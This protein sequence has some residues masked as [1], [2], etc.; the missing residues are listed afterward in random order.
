MGRGSGVDKV[1][2]VVGVHVQACVG[3]GGSHGT[4]KLKT[5]LLWLGFQCALANCGGGNGIGGEVMWTRQR[6]WWV[7]TFEHMMV[8]YYKS[9]S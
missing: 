2:V 1:M 9:V 4:K 8:S 6:R 7:Y 3:G 5:E